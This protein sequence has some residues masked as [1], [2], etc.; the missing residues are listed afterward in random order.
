MCRNNT[1]ER[2]KNSNV[3]LYIWVKKKLQFLKHPKL[4]PIHLHMLEMK[5]TQG[6]T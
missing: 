5:Y 1:C 2:E 3:M 4:E 6:L